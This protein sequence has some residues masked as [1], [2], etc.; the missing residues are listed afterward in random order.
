LRAVDAVSTWAAWRYT[1]L[2]AKAG[3]YQISVR[4]TDGTG[5]LQEAKAQDSFPLGATG[6][7]TITVQVH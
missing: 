2:P 1:W 3:S 4:A 5:T 7:H 6:L